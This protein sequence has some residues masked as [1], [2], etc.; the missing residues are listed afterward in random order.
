MNILQKSQFIYVD[1]VLVLGIK[2]GVSA[3]SYHAIKESDIFTVKQ[4]Q[5]SI[6]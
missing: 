1:M 3:I 5:Q 4:G 2:K 6:K